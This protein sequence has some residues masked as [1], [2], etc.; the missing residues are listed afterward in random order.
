[1]IGDGCCVP[2][3]SRLQKKTCRPSAGVD[4]NSLRGAHV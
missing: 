3:W 1:M 4:T 2:P